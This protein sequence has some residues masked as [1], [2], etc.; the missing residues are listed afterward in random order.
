MLHKYRLLTF[1]ESATVFEYICFQKSFSYI[2]HIQLHITPEIRL[3]MLPNASLS[4]DVDAVSAHWF[5]IRLL[6]ITP[7]IRLSM[8]LN[9]SLSN[10]V[11]AISAHWFG[12]ILHSTEFGEQEL[13]RMLMA[14]ET[15]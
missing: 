12:W 6:H 11:D 4:N 2:N 14:G 13:L 10:D 15:C 5:A 7:K 9:A 1:M 3:S 8:L